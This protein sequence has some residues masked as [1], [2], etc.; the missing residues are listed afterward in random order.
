MRLCFR[1]HDAAKSSRIIPDVQRDGRVNQCSPCGLRGTIIH[2]FIALFG[3]TTYTT[4]AARHSRR[5]VIANLII[6][7]PDCRTGL[8]RLLCSRLPF[9]RLSLAR[10]HARPI[11]VC[12][13]GNM[14]TLMGWVAIGLVLGFLANAVVF[15]RG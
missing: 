11:F 8:E 9:L 1:P 2:F 13:G 7:L 6:G 10:E 5:P 4:V 3:F 12:P 15:R 14:M